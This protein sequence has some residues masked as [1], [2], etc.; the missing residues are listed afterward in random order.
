MCTKENDKYSGNLGDRY[1]GFLTPIL[2]LLYVSL[3]LFY[4]KD[5]KPI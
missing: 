2:Y 5:F 3:K 4:N 1:I